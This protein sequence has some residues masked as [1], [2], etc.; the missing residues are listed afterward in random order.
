MS[1]VLS[2]EVRLVWFGYILDIGVKEEE[3]KD[4]FWF[5]VY[6]VRRLVVLFLEIEKIGEGI[7]FVLLLSLIIVYIVFCFF[8]GSK[9]IMISIFWILFVV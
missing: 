4:E 9:I 3:I 2:L 1:L 7:N 5:L 6:V 8:K